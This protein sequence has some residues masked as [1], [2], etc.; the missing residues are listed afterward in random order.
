[1]AMGLA[2]RTEGFW[3]AAVAAQGSAPGAAG[4][5]GVFVINE[6]D[7]NESL[8]LSLSISMLI[9]RNQRQMV[10]SLEMFGVTLGRL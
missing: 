4:T 10:K 8:T 5:G 9:F 1:M 3:F 6:N 7:P 2:V